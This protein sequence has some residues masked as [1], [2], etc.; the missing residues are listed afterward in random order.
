MSNNKQST[1][2]IGI[3]AS[4]GHRGRDQYKL[5]ISVIWGRTHHC[6]IK[7]ET[8]AKTVIGLIIHHAVFHIAYYF[9]SPEQKAHNLSY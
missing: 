1:N 8:I 3:G 5:K 6:V 2:N 9:S 4:R 7:E